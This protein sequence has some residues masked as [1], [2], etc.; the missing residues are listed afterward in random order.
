M[1]SPRLEIGR[2]ERRHPS[3]ASLITGR[4]LQVALGVFWLIAGLLQLQSYM[5]THAFVAQVLEP[6]AAGQPSVI[7]DPIVTF[8]RFYGRDLPLWNTLAAELQCAIGLGLIV[9][10]RAVRPALAVSFVWAIIVWWLGEG[11]GRLTASPE[12]SPLMGAPGAVIL[13]A[14]VGAALWPVLESTDRRR[15][16]EQREPIHDRVAGYAWAGLW[17]VSA[18]LWCLDVN[19]SKNAIADQLAGM[20]AAS[21]RW[22]AG[23]QNAAAGAAHGHGEL[24]ALGLAAVSLLVGLGVFSRALRLPAVVLGVGLSVAYWILGQSLGGPFW[25]GDATDVNTA[26]LFVLLGLVLVPASL[27]RPVAGARARAKAVVVDSDTGDPRPLGDEDA[28]DHDRRDG[29]GARTDMLV[30]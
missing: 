19:R 14:L 7:G 3:P 12:S 2:G 17:L 18:I 11:F 25:A 8:A 5:Y 13:Y 1:S 4:G 28:D 23:W 29:E 6:G 22:L 9:T 30:E 10:R 27:R 15:S 24:P 26:P 21:P 20:A 16:P